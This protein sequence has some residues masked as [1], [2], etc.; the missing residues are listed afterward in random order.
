MRGI[1]FGGDVGGGVFEVEDGGADGGC[2]SAGYIAFA[3]LGCALDCHDGVGCQRF[4]HYVGGKSVFHGRHSAEDTRCTYT[5]GLSF[6]LVIWGLW[7][8]AFR[9]RHVRLLWIAHVFPYQIRDFL[10]ND[11]Y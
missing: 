11:D 10:S 1:G 3:Y 4:V 2:H 7:G 9:R 6:L 8:L 5:L